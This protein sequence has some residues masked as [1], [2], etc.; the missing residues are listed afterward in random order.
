MSCESYC[1]ENNSKNLTRKGEHEKNYLQTLQDAVP[2]QDPDF[3]HVILLSPIISKLPL[4]RTNRIWSLYSKVPL[5]SLFVLKI[6]SSDSSGFG[7][8]TVPV[9]K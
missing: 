2:D 6:T 3:V 7:H 4:Q 8:V 5:L 1:F 9:Q